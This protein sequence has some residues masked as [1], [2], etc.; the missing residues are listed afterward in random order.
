MPPPYLMQ[1]LLMPNPIES[2]SFFF[3]ASQLG[4]GQG[5][6]SKR[7]TRANGRPK[8]VVDLDRRVKL[9]PVVRCD[10]RG[11]GPGEQLDLL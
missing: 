4:Y 3:S 11:R 6:K 9:C 1:H 7:P 2:F 5:R 8:V 10:S